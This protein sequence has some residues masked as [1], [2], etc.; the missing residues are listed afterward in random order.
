[1]EEK[2]YKVLSDLEKIKK[3]I[4]RTKLQNVLLRQELAKR[5]MENQILK[6]NLGANFIE[7]LLHES[8]FES[9]E[10]QDSYLKQ[11]LHVEQKILYGNEEEEKNYVLKLKEKLN[12]EKQEDIDRLYELLWKYKG[13]VF[14]TEEGRKF[15]EEIQSK[16]SK[17]KY[18]E[19]KCSILN[20]IA[21]VCICLSVIVLIPIA[22]FC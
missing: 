3:I 17:Y 7:L 11:I 12:L 21:I 15:V 6:S 16:T 18:M 14:R 10:A 1:M 22:Y 13:K 19:R 5:L 20:K 8:Y 9:E 2:N 4:T